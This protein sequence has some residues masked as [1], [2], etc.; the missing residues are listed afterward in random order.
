MA[1]IAE[2]NGIAVGNV[3]KVNGIAK[4]A[5]TNVQGFTFPAGGTPTNYLN[6][7]FDSLTE[8]YNSSYVPSNW[9]MALS[10][11]IYGT[12]NPTRLW[13]PEKGVTNSGTTGPSNAHGGSTTSGAFS[14][15][16]GVYM[17]TEASGLL[18]KSP[19]VVDPP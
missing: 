9:S 14:S 15:S 19:D 2:I 1:E 18:L 17:Y 11:I 12:T 7:S 4:S 10:N 13:E 8:G 3:S 5:L 16:T 6:E